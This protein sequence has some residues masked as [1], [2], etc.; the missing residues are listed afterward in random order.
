LQEIQTVYTAQLDTRYV[1]EG[2]RHSVVLLIDDQW[3]SAH[4][5]SPVA[6]LSL[7]SPNLSGCFDFLEIHLASELAQNLHGFLSL[8]DT[9]DGIFNDQWEFRYLINAMPSGH[10]QRR[11]G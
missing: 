9:L 1:S 11:N 4:N 10:D 2:S 6:H 7:S 5:V 8:F 3:A